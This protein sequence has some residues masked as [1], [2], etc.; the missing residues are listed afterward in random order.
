M[1]AANH[2]LSIS[3]QARLLMKRMSMEALY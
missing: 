3:R 1:I 2:K